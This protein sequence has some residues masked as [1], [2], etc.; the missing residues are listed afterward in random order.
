M[1]LSTC[2]PTYPP[3]PAVT[4]RRRL[5]D[6][7][8]ASCEGLRWRVMEMDDGVGAADVVFLVMDG[9]GVAWCGMVFIGDLCEKDG[10]R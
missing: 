6:G 8:G 3:K 2:L 1:S 10:G 7:E 4:S 5:D 9:W